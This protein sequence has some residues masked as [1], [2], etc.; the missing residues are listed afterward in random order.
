MD[1]MWIMFGF[2]WKNLF[3]HLVLCCLLCPFDFA[4]PGHLFCWA[5]PIRAPLSFNC[6]V[7]AQVWILLWLVCGV[8]TFGIELRRSWIRFAF[9]ILYS[10]I[11]SPEAVSWRFPVSRIWFFGV[12]H[13]TKLFIRFPRCSHETCKLTWNG[14]RPCLLRQIRMLFSSKQ[15]RWAEQLR[16]KYSNKRCE[17][18]H[19]LIDCL[20]PLAHSP[21][22]FIQ[23]Q[24]NRL[25]FLYNSYFQMTSRLQKFLSLSL[26]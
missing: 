10:W 24:L 18:V 2:Q 21:W 13:A 4:R 26:T 16:T 23:S 8:L 14:V 12:S 6:C 1:R 20:L 19:F 22:A 11:V 5:S 25:L 15:Q 9:P 3:L 17:K 7:S